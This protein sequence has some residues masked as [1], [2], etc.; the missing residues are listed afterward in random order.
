[1]DDDQPRRRCVEFFT[2]RQL[3]KIAPGDDLGSRIVDAF[4]KD[5]LNFATGDILVVAQKIVSKAE[6]RYVALSNVL[7]SD[8]AHELAGVCKKDPRLVELVL[9]E[10]REV[11]RCRPGV[12]IVENHRG[13]V[14]ANAGIDRSNIDQSDHDERVLL[15]PSD[16]DASCAALRKRIA[17][18]T[19]AQV[20]VIINDSIGRA[21]RNG[22]HGTA[23]GVSGVRALQ[24]LRGQPDL[25]GYVLQTTEVGTAD[26]IAAAA[27]LLMGQG[28]EGTPVVLI[29]GLQALLG[30]G[31]AKDLIRKRAEDLFR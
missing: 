29:S 9:R 12:I 19:G 8:R 24:D 13:V 1:M 3:G 23:I 20:G 30:D 7:P 14:L 18:L 26:E 5:S 15:L 25:F 6:G 27:S 10:S 22:T 2:T 17:D 21:W 11:L 4:G 16:P 31:K 28:A